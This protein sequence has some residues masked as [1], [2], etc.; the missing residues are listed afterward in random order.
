MSLKSD[1]IYI[2]AIVKD[3]DLQ[4]LLRTYVVHDKCP[5]DDSRIQIY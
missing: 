1:F 3:S 4:T 5:W 2:T